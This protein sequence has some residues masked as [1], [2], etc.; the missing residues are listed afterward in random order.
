MQKNRNR[1]LK[2]T[3]H[4]KRIRGFT[5]V[6]LLVV[7]AIIGVLVALLLPAI[8]AAR[9]SARRT[10]C[11]NQVRQIVL[12]LQNYHS[13]QG[14]FPPGVVNDKD[15]LFTFPRLTWMMHTFSYLEQ[16]A[17]VNAFDL[18]GKDLDCQ[19][20][21]WSAKKNQEVVKVPI[22]MLRCPSDSEG[23]VV[24]NHPDCGI[25][26]S[27]GNYAGFFGNVNMGAAVDE[28]H[29][30]RADHRAAPFTMNERVRIGM[31]TDGTSNTMVV[32]EILKGISNDKDIR[33]VFWYD[34]VGTSQILTTNGPNSPLPDFLFGPWCT[35]DTNRPDLNLPCRP[36]R[37]AAANN[38]NHAA[39]RSRHPGGVHIGMA[40]GSARYTSE[41][42]DLE[43]W[44]AL[45]S[46]SY[47]EVAEGQ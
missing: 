23:D 12:A 26:I 34:H 29:P 35:N 8:Q 39:A 9:A 10:T 32:G 45:G 37:P 30:D 1:G 38:N 40:D 18:N 15:E 42:V 24:H 33:G 14:A 27:R 3:P 7:I 11:L 20:G 2:F 36:G 25:E 22:E 6:E 16:T 19:N 5:L 46:I 4:F 21:V 47:G 28:M 17:V 41:D 44:Q 13:S 31:I 43:V